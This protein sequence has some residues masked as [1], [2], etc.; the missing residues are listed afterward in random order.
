MRLRR[1]RSLLLLSVLAAG[2]LAGCVTTLAPTQVLPREAN[3]AVTEVALA[4][5]PGAIK[6]YAWTEC[7]GEDAT[8]TCV[9]VYSRVTMG[10]VIY[11]Y[12]FVQTIG[13]F[14]RYPDGAVNS[15]GDAYVVWSE[16]TDFITCYDYWTVFPA[17]HPENVEPTSGYVDASHRQS[18]DRPVVVGR[19]LDVYAAYYVEVFSAVRLRYQQLNGGNRTGY[20]DNTTLNPEAV[21]LVVD[22]NGDLHAVWVRNPISDTVVV[23]ANNIGSSDDLDNDVH[24]YN[25]GDET[26]VTNPDLAL[27]DDDRAY[28]GYSINFGTNDTVRVRCIDAPAN[29][30]RSDADLI[31]PHANG[32]W[33]LYGN[34]HL[35]M[36]SDQPNLVFSATNVA[37]TYNEVW[38]YH[39][40]DTGGDVAP[41]QVTDTNTTNEGEPLI[42]EEHSDAG[43]VPVVGW[44]RYQNFILD[45]VGPAGNQGHCE[46]DVF[47]TYANPS[48]TRKVFTDRGTCGNSGLD[49]AANGAWVAGVWIDEE[50]DALPTHA[51]WTAFNAYGAY[52]PFAAK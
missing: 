6:H 15:A 46:G 49:L 32:N 34:V 8:Y 21:S 18:E 36:I 12:G 20:I 44:R 33:N 4:V 9:L 39:P 27:D 43:D 13:E 38:W 31:V 7:F 10:A 37:E 5:G 35:E 42:V 41:T 16:C 30:Y 26:L 23:Y 52:L 17:T 48:N 47:V 24:S 45:V 1:A 28:V 11:S 2:L 3:A 40:P 29:C 14:A 19:G 25:E 22:S 51:A 50:S